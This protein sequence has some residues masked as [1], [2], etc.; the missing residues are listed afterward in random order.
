MNKLIGICKELE[1]KLFLDD[2]DNKIVLDKNGNE[3]K[4]TNINYDETIKINNI[5]R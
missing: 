3:I 1:Y 5:N 4:I 2:N